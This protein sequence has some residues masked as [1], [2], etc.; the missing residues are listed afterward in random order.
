MASIDIR[1]KGDE[2]VTDIVFADQLNTSSYG[3]QRLEKY[4]DDMMKIHW[5]GDYGYIAFKD[6]DNMI[7]ALQKAKEIWQ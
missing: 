1:I 5:D 2:E 6:V 7:E 3:M 4:S